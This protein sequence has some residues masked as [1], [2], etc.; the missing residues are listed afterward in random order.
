MNTY[1]KEN[2]NSKFRVVIHRPGD[3]KSFI[4]ADQ[5]DIGE[6]KSKFNY[7]IVDL[8]DDDLVELR[9]FLNEVV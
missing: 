5:R 1:T 7:V 2:E 4:E 3:N 9:D 6:K 8:S